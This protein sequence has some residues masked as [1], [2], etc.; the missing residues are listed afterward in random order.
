MD[1]CLRKFL[2]FL[3]F[4]KFSLDTPGLELLYLIMP[5][6]LHYQAQKENTT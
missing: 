1:L 2:K 5:A 3:E 6:K 4:L